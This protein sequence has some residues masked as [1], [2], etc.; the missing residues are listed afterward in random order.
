MVTKAFATISLENLIETNE[1]STISKNRNEFD[2]KY[3]CSFA[4][5]NACDMFSGG[6]EK[7]HCHLK[8]LLEPL[9][10]SDSHD[11]LIK[12]SAKYLSSFFFKKCMQY[13]YEW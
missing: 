10:F 11:F 12:F 8:I 2:A 4:M 7:T 5:K 1:L 3:F 13:T 9:R 6:K